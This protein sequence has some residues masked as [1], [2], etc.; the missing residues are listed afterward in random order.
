LAAN[1]CKTS[2]GR[3]IE[4]ELGV[5]TVGAVPNVPHRLLLGLRRSHTPLMLI[6]PAARAKASFSPADEAVRS[7]KIAIDHYCRDKSR[8]GI[9]S[10]GSAEGKTTLAFNLALLAAQCGRRALLIDANLRKRRLS[11]LLAPDQT[12]GLEALVCQNADFGLCTK[13]WEGT[14]VFLG[15]TSGA[16]RYSGLSS[17]GCATEKGLRRLRLCD[18]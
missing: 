17:H 1:F 11:S 12:E 5:K 9:T 6:D 4:T 13:N 8:V 7:L 18:S 10:A 14:F 15:E 2:F 16:V 3:Q